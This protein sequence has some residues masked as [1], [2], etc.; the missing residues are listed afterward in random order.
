VFDETQLLLPQR[1]TAPQ[2]LAHICCSHKIKGKD[3]KV[4]LPSQT[5]EIRNNIISIFFHH[6]PD[7]VM[8][9]I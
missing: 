1:G 5:N 9:I 4:S 7:V 8:K 3:N 6:I 2:F